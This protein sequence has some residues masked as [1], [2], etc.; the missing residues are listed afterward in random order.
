MKL[1][2]LIV[3]IIFAGATSC[4]KDNF[5]YSGI[6]DGRHEG[7]NMLEYMQAHPYDWDS[8]RVMIHHAGDDMVKLFEGKDERHK[9]FTF[10]GMTNH[11]IRR[12]LLQHNLKQVSD[13]DAEWCRTIL[14]KHLID[15]K[16]YRKEIPAGEPGLYETV[17]T[18]GTTL[19]TLAG[20]KIWT[21]VGVEEK[22]GVVQHAS[23]P[24]YI[25]FEESGRLLQVVSGDIEPDNCLV[26]ALDYRFTIGEEE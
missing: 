21:Y 2:I 4:T 14:L 24:I 10:F 15:G 1:N 6:S 11:S 7:K 18:G 20:T 19:T 5:Y 17:G 12:Y 8:T 13:L 3:L 26:H 16:L 25:R 23:R 22:N 9:E